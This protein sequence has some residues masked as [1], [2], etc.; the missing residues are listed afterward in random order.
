MNWRELI[1]SYGIS[2][3][4]LT[5]KHGPCPICTGKD[6]FRFDD[7]GKGMYYCNNCGAGDGYSLIMKFT[8]Q[9]FKTIKNKIDAATGGDISTEMEKPDYTKNIKPFRAILKLMKPIINTPV[10]DYLLSRS[11]SLDTIK[12]CNGLFYLR[13]ADRWHGGQRTQ[14]DCMIAGVRNEQPV[15]LHRTY[16]QKGIKIDRK[17]MP[18]IRESKGMAIQLFKYEKTLGIA[19]G[20][21]TAL[22]CFE[23]FG[24]PTWSVI[25]TAGIKGFN[26]P[27]DTNIIIFADNDENF[28]GQSVAYEKAK[29][30][31]NKDYNVTVK[32]PSKKGYDF[33]DVLRD[34]TK[35]EA[36]FR[37]ENILI[38]D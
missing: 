29:E 2:P 21:E 1:T 31:H 4:F 19:E 36:D 25:S 23:L 33:N 26:P 30:L 34:S 7:K 13:N 11:I 14:H 10:E 6:R 38:D 28:A 37:K 18:V 22:S 9:D 8:G 16:L 35:T 5:G 20:I 27:K 24:I 32:V 3:S 17:L 12:Q 15:T